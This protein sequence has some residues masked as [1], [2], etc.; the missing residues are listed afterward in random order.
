MRLLIIALL[1]LTMVGAAIASETIK[2]YPFTVVDGSTSLQAWQV[3]LSSDS[4]GN[5][6]YNPSFHGKLYS[7]QIEHNNTIA[8]LKNLTITSERPYSLLMQNYNLSTGN[9][10]LFP[11]SGSNMYPLFGPVNFTLT[12]VSGSGGANADYN[13][14]LALGV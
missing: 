5:A 10:T 14:I 12:N 9:A 2:L 6:T 13:F 7:I 1:A 11:R 4:D 8:G 3:T